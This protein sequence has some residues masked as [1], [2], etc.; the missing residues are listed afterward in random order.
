[1]SET[2]LTCDMDESS[3]M[4]Q[5]AIAQGSLAVQKFETE[6]DIA[7]HVKNFFDAK[8]APGWHCICGKSFNCA[9]TFEAKTYAFYQIG[10][11]MI[12]LFKS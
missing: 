6:K 9:A 8:Y 4:R 5:D 7:K 12:L 10:P 11:M 2:M 3:E 1:M